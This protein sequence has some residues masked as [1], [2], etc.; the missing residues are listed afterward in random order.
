PVL[1]HIDKNLKKQIDERER[2]FLLYESEGKISD[3]VHDPSQQAPRLSTTDPN[4][5]DHYGFIHEQP[6]KS[7]SINE[8]K[9]IHQEIKR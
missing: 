9:Q 3:I 8:R 1:T 4:C 6:T 2:L 7:L 5:I